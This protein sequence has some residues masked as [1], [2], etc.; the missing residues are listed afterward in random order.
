[1]SQTP[2][3]RFPRKGSENRESINTEATEYSKS[4]TDD[5]SAR[6]EEASFDPKTTDPEKEKKLAGEGEV[7]CVTKG[8]GVR[9]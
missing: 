2:F 9:C 1:L 4:G 5:A 6:Q 7:C 3:P 8:L